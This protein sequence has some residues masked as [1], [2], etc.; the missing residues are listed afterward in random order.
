VAANDRKPPFR[1]ITP[2]PGERLKAIQERTRSRGRRGVTVRA[3]SAG[4]RAS[5]SAVVTATTPRPR[6]D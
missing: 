5:Q 1:D 3:F 4:C 2:A 6:P